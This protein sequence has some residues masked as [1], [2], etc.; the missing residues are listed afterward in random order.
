MCMTPSRYSPP[1]SPPCVI[2]HIFC[3]YFAFRS[4]H[5]FFKPFKS[6]FASGKLTPTSH[7]DLCT[8]IVLLIVEPRTPIPLLPPSYNI[9]LF[10]KETFCCFRGEVMFSWKCTGCVRWLLLDTSRENALLQRC[11]VN[12]RFRDHPGGNNYSCGVWK[13]FFNCLLHL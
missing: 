5:T 2:Q 11:L 7:K 1:A 10:C 8:S 12:E 9:W 6:I 3:L 4:T 13:V